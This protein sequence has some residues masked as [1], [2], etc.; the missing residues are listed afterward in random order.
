MEIRKTIQKLQQ[1]EV[2]KLEDIQEWEM[3]LL[4]YKDME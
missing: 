2:K 3:S 4:I 1:L